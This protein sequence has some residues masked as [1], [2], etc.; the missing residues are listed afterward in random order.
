MPGYAPFAPLRVTLASCPIT[1][2]L[3]VFHAS[4]PLLSRGRL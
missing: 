1:L 4:F 2:T 3:P